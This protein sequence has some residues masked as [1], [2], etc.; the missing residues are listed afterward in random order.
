[1][2]GRNPPARFLPGHSERIFGL[3]V[4]ELL[5][6]RRT[7]DVGLAFGVDSDEQVAIGREFDEAEDGAIS[8]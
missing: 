7:P 8:G 1:M 5:Q 4:S 3:D 6:R 2:A